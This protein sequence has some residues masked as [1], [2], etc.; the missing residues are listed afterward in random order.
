MN[1]RSI[2]FY[3]IMMLSVAQGFSQT[4]SDPVN[5]S[6]P[7]ANGNPDFAVDNSGEIHCVWSKSVGYLFKKI[8]YSKSADKGGTWTNP[9]AITSN[10][11]L[12][13]DNP[14]IIADTSGNL[15]V[16]YDYNVG[17][18][19]Q[20]CFT[21]F[22]RSTAKWSQQTTI[23]SGTSNRLAVDNNNR[24]YFFWFA[25]TEY[26]R[27]L[28]H[29]IL[30]DSV[31]PDFGTPE[32]YFFDDIKADKQNSIHC[33]GNRTAGANSKG[34][35]FSCHNGAWGPFFDLSNGSFFES[36]LSLNSIGNPSFVWRQSLPDSLSDIKGTFYNRFEN[37]TIESPLLLARETTSPAIVLDVNDQPHIVESQSIAGGSQLLHRYISGGTW[38]FDVIESNQ[39]WYGKN[40]LISN[41]SN[42]LLVYN[43]IDT[44]L[45]P[46]S[47]SY[48][49]LIMFRHM[50]IASGCSNNN[51][52]LDLKIY[53]NPFQNDVVVEWPRSN[54][55][56]ALLRIFDIYGRIIYENL[57]DNMNQEKFII[58]WKGND[59]FGNEVKGGCYFVRISTGSGVVVKKIIRIGR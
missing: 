15:Y 27:Y 24:V 42:I 33:I 19:T 17:G 35:Y 9:V 53:P 16:S 38:Q 23:G 55:K 18:Y 6:G 37:D 8:Y 46:S 2:C 44:T 28:E 51:H 14:H 49:G 4:W 7:G 20:I 52:N 57:C 22:T 48:N 56:K 29:N 36:G 45:I 31:S 50:E 32:R 34:A 21:K 30:S 58:V 43:K 26:Y 1:L 40:I 12:W 11:K 41:N 54:T 13:L 47:S 39:N 10:Q 25:S 5:I 59:L 3:T